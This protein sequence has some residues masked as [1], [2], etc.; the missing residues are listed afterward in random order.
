MEPYHGEIIIDDPNTG[1]QRL[2]VVILVNDMSQTTIDLHNT[3]PPKGIAS[4][5]GEYGKA[6]TLVKV[7]KAFC[8][9]VFEMTFL[10]HE[11][12]VRVRCFTMHKFGQ[13][14]ENAI[15]SWKP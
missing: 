8:V 14:L 5:I 4:L 13:R 2:S 9:T 11:P 7:K 15:Q 12:P 3:V 10:Y 1:R 6:W